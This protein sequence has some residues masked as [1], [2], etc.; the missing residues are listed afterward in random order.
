M[1]DTKA[2]KK[3]TVNYRQYLAYRKTYNTV[4]N[5]SKAGTINIWFSISFTSFIGSITVNALIGNIEFHIVKA[6]IPFL[7]CL[8]NIDILKV[9]YN[10]FK[11]TLVT[12]I[13][14]V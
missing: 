6:N 8:T 4:I 10:N 3:S 13:K 7:L 12:L 1:I 11:N 9:Y 5:T 2:S 14:S